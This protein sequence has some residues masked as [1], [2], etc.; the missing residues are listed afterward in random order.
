[1]LSSFPI[2][3]LEPL[4]INTVS[5]SEYIYRD[6]VFRMIVRNIFSLFDSLVEAVFCSVFPLSPYDIGASLLSLS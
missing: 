1:M 6:A 5:F 2:I 4:C 3:P